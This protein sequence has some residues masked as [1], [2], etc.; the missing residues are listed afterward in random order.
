MIKVKDRVAGTPV[1]GAQSE[2]RLVGQPRGVTR[3]GRGGTVGA[4]EGFRHIR[5]VVS[6]KMIT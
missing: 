4:A 6:E 3:R 5:S 2:L 1:L